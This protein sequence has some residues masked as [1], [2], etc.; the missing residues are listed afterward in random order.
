VPLSAGERLGPYEVLGPIGAGG[1]G[2]VYRA[3]DTRLDRTVALKILPPELAASTELKARFERE[4]RAIAALVH[5]NI[6]T[7]HDVGEQDGRTFLVMEH[8]VGETL[9]QRLKKG[10]LLLDHALEIATQVADALSAAHKAGVIHRDLKPANIMLTK[11]GARLLDFGLARLTAHGQRPAVENLTSAPTESQPL[12]GQG[13]IMGTLPYMAPEQVE[14]KPADARTD[15]WALGTILYEML[16]GE[17]PFQAESATSLVGAILERT[18]APITERQPLTPPSLDRLVRRCLAKDPDDRWDTAHD[19]ADELRWVAEGCTLEQPPGGP[20]SRRVGPLRT[21]LVVAGGAVMILVLVLP[22][23]GRRPSKEGRVVRASLH[24]PQ[25][26]PLDT[27]ARPPFALSPDGSTVAYVSAGAEGRKIRVHR[28]DRDEGTILPGTDETLGLFFSPNGRELAFFARDA[29]RKISLSSGLVTKL[30]DFEAHPWWTDGHWG[31]GGTIVFAS[32]AGVHAVHEEGGQAPRLLTAARADRLLVFP[33]LLPGGNFILLTM[34]GAGAIDSSIGILSLNNGAIKT[35]LPGGMQALYVRTGHLI[36]LKSGLLMA[37][38]FD[39]SH[40]NLAGPPFELPYEV[41][42]IF[43]GTFSIS[44]SGHLLYLQAIRSRSLVWV[45]RSGTASSV[46][47]AKAR[48]F[49]PRLAPDGRAIA[50][51][52][53]SRATAEIWLVDPDRGTR[54]LLTSDGDGRLP[55]WT[56]DGQRVTFSSMRAGGRKIYWRRADGTGESERIDTGESPKHDTD[57]SWHPDGAVLAHTAYSEDWRIILTRPGSSGPPEP[58]L[59]STYRNWEPRFSPDG[60]WLAYSSYQ[61]GTSEVYVR[62]F[63][64]GSARQQVSV[65]GG[66]DPVWARDGRELF[67]MRDG[68]LYV[69]SVEAGPQLTLG[70]PRLLFQGSYLDVPGA[71]SYDVSL[72][73]DRFLMVEVSEEE[74]HPTRL[75]IVVN[76]FRELEDLTGAH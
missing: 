31:E 20:S 17:R 27:T 74:R 8:L 76:F 21:L 41:G 38:P 32:P 75:D 73:G 67:Y 57:G 9:A 36:F 62:S 2:E 42:E 39:P 56:P 37:A 29:L 69:V 58:F 50:V 51:E 63:P 59:E 18:P 19:V 34:T 72:D 48:Y 35:L 54:T 46:H 7:L 5:P 10:P 45:D 49:Q 66:H 1:M 26:A 22:W 53:A 71:G 65:G 25:D 16:T 6:C 15:L 40:G 13:T 30:C 11:T 3:R 52:M 28:L 33:R 23:F 47:P 4:A 12:T 55:L 14:G 61:S 60:R 24:L 43:G 44:D 70:P 64:E 68:G